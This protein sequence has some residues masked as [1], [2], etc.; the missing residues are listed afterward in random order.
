MSTYHTANFY[1]MQRFLFILLSLLSILPLRAQ[2]DD[3][4]YRLELGAGVGLSKNFTD[5]KDKSGIAGALVARFPLNP[6]MAVKTQFTYNTIKGSTTGNKAFLP[7]NPNAV[8]SERLNYSVS[9]AVYDLS[10]LYELHFLPYGYVRDYRGY[11]RVVPYVQMG[12]GLTYGSCKSFT[13]N[14]PL[15]IGVKYKVAQ[16]LNLGFDWLVHFSLSDK[17]DGLEA[18]LGIKSEMFRNKDIFSSFMLTLTYDLRPKCPTC[19]RD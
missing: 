11:V 18:P 9:A 15:G 4:F 7:S 3:P 19:N 2:Q 17:L 5:V 16:R 1:L 6:R 14:I 10:A 8:G 13:A 12:F